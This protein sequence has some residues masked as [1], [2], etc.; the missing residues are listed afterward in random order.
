MS[1]H[2]RFCWYEL[3]AR[4]PDAAQTFYCA[5]LGW[6]VWDAGMT[7]IDYRL[8]GPSEGGAVAG[9]MPIMESAS[10][11]IWTG[12]VC[13][14]DVDAAAASAKSSGATIY[15]APL[16]IP[17]VGRFAI[18]SDPQGASLAMLQPLPNAPAPPADV[19]D[20][21]GRVGWHELHAGDWQAAWD[22][23]APLF[24]WQGT[25]MEMGPRGI[26]FLFRPNGL[27]RD[28]G[29]IFTA[30]DETPSWIFYF[31]VAELDAATARV[32]AAGGTLGMGPHQVPGSSWIQFCTDPQGAPF[33][34]TALVR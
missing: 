34:L 18:L 32:T 7:G 27:E 19:Y 26:Y 8:A 13:V 14:D 25:P 22:F 4:D 2:G 28:I 9:L 5:V 33:A 6:T 31:N 12:Y 23:H 30:A 24:R 20:A 21:V 3:M 17:G 10:R 1:N 29:G 16:D 11:P 15:R